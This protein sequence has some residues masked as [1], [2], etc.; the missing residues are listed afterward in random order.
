MRRVLAVALVLAGSMLLAQVPPVRAE[1]GGEPD[2]S[3]APGLERM[4]VHVLAR[5][6]HVVV[7]LEG[8][9]VQVVEASD[10]A[11]GDPAEVP[12]DILD[13][14][15]REVWVVAQGRKTRIRYRDGNEIERRTWDRGSG[16]ELDPDLHLLL[17]ESLRGPLIPEIAVPEAEAVVET[18]SVG[19]AMPAADLFGDSLG[20]LLAG[21]ADEATPLRWGGYAEVLL[22]NGEDGPSPH[23]FDSGLSGNRGLEVR[24]GVLHLDAY[25]GDQTRF[26]GQIRAVRFNNFDL[27][28]AMLQIGD[29]SGR[30]WRLGRQHHPFGSFVLRNLADRNPVYGYPLGYSYRSSLRADQAPAG[31]AAIQAARGGGGGGAGMSHAGPA[32]YQ[33]YMLYS[34]P[35]GDTGRFT[36]GLQNGSLGANE[37]VTRNDAFGLIGQL[38]FDPKPSWHFGASA[39]IAP[40][41]TSG[42]TGLA[43]GETPEDFDQTLIG[44]ELRYSRGRF[45]VDAELMWNDWEVSSNAGV[46][47]LGSFSWYLEGVWNLRPKLFTAFRY[48]EITFDDVPTGAGT[49]APWDFDADR[50]E[51]GFG[52]RPTLNL[53][54]KLSAQFNGTETNPEPEADSVVLQVIGKF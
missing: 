31:L 38:T 53:L 3:G 23:V 37:N 54:T 22:M 43:A 32:F 42:A 1:S 41:M 4:L 33:T 10:P 5:G 21:R 35:V 30:H 26:F 17:P 12:R 45:R 29:P 2:E 13:E 40:Y 48:S 16:E 47:E 6:L 24:E 51:V 8:G 39:S 19:A 49:S 44:L 36:F 27:R 9:R 7:G 46:P 18:G 50:L 25:M 28:V 34:M 20:G 11:T 52:Y 14:P 15:G